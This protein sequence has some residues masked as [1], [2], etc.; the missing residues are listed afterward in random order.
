MN[1]LEI[2]NKIDLPNEIEIEKAVLGSILIDKNCL[3]DVQ[4]VLKPKCFYLKAHQ[5]IYASMVD[6]FK[7]NEGIDLYTVTFHLKKSNNLDNAG[8]S[9][10]LAELTQY[11]NSSINVSSYCLMI[12]E[13]YIQRR[14]I[15]ISNGIL[16]ESYKDDSDVFDL[17]NRAE[18]SIIAI[19]NE[20]SDGK[21]GEQI[22]KLCDEF[23]T[24]I[25]EPVDESKGIYSGIAKLDQV[26]GGFKN[27]N[28]ITIA[29]ATSM[30]K[31][32]FATNIIVNNM[33]NEKKVLF[34]SLEMLSEE[35]VPKILSSIS[36]VNSFKIENKHL[37]NDQEIS[38]IADAVNLVKKNDNLFLECGYSNLDDVRRKCK[39][40]KSRK[41]I[42]LI[43]LDHL[44]LLS[45]GNGRGKT[46]ELE[47]LS[48]MTK[49]FKQIAMELEVP[50]FLL[51][52]LNRDVSK[53][54][55]KRPHLNHLR[56]SGSIEQD[57][58]VVLM[59]HRDDYYKSPDEPKD[60]ITEVLIRKNRSGSTGMV[61]VIYDPK[62]N[63]F[64]DE[65]TY[66]RSFRKEADEF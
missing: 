8:G 7:N 17:L 41:G 32:S 47:R 24:K 35:I 20:I 1:N 55:D 56:G 45:I 60:N 53:E 44:H 31:T 12:K 54:K 59:L 25:Y 9:V 23:Y 5:V 38:K 10:Y 62:T 22:G 58:N 50:F 26:F 13:K 16:Q 27:G 61:K 42:D 48:E 34:F 11:V 29:A 40:Y 2:K 63:K 19:N 51:A 36:G 18:N 46:T 15:A 52:Q 57:S 4:E 6:L 30:G 43:V 39:S 65:N 33:L 14:L 3:I 37:L 66:I 21:E 49:T 64:E 28:L